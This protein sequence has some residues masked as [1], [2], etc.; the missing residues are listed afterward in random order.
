MQVKPGIVDGVG[1]A[2]YVLHDT[3]EEFRK[4][5]MIHNEKLEQI[6]RMDPKDF[7]SCDIE[8]NTIIKDFLVTVNAMESKLHQSCPSWTLHELEF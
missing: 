7:R 4:D 2:Q 6:S 5:L 8:G 3:Y 1:A